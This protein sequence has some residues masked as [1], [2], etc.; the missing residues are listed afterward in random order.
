M[1]KTNKNPRREKVFRI[2][3]AITLA[4]VLWVYVNG[5]SI[6]LVTQDLKDIPVTLT[7]TDT[8]KENG[9]V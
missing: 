7:N 8:L 9:L 3:I 2:C 6:D 1:I 4:I 5:T